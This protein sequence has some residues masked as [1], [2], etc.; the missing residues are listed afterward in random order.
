MKKTNEK[1]ETNTLIA[2]CNSCGEEIHYGD[3]YQ[4]IERSLEK[5][6]LMPK[7]QKDKVEVFDGERFWLCSKCAV[8]VSKQA[9][10]NYVRQ[11]TQIEPDFSYQGEKMGQ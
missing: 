7:K 11:A 6:H 5:R 4:T 1:E 10:E 9:L 2:F 3:A 8:H